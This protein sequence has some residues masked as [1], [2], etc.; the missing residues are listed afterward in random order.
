MAGYGRLPADSDALRVTERSAA[1]Q[2]GAAEVMVTIDRPEGLHEAG[3]PRRFRSELSSQALIER[4]PRNSF[5][6]TLENRQPDALGGTGK[7]LENS[8]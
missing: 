5:G 6:V 4:C 7:I 2:T 3:G 1:L 8:G